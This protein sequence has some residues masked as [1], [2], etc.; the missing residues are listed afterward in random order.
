LIRHNIVIPDVAT[1]AVYFVKLKWITIPVV[2]VLLAMRGSYVLAVV[3]LVWSWL[4]GLVGY[5]PGR[6]VGKTQK[7]FMACLGYETRNSDETA[8]RGVVTSDHPSEQ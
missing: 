5:V 2:V 4:A 6:L 7:L 3:S 8:D 1:L